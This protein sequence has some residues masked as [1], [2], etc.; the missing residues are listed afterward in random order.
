MAVTLCP[1]SGHHL[2]IHLHAHKHDYLCGGFEFF[3]NS[4]F[5]QVLHI[6]R[7]VLEMVIF[8][9]CAG[10]VVK[11][12]CRNGLILKKYLHRKWLLYHRK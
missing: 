7:N 8:T 9:N 12:D 11:N 2:H 10:N 1:E 3:H 4:F 5:K 6:C